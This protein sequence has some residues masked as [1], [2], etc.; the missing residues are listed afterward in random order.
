MYVYASGKN[1]DKTIVVTAD[2]GGDGSNGTI[3][4]NKKNVFK[5]V[6]KTNLCN[7]GRMYRMQLIYGF[8]PTNTNTRS[9]V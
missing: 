2:G 8:K 1:N 6:Y 7:I 4:I 3:W 5:Q 9:W